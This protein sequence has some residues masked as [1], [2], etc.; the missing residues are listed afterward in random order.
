[1]PVLLFE[2]ILHK[3]PAAIPAELYDFTLRCK[4]EKPAAVPFVTGHFWE[5]R[6]KVQPLLDEMAV[7][8]CMA[9]VDL[10]PIRAGIA[11][12]P[13]TSDFTSVQERIVDR[14]L[15]MNHP[16]ESEAPSSGLAA[17]CSPG[18]EAKGRGENAQREKGRGG[19]TAV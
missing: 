4:Q 6:Y 18:A 1:M 8:A 19:C 9:Y 14:R 2:G 3:I 11:L 15:A 12:T 7:A 10:N 13:E 16:E 5:A 17:T